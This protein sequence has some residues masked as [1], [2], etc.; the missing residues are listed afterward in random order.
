[1]QLKLAPWNWFKPSSKIFLLTIWRRYFFCGSFVLFM[2]CVCN[3][4]ASVHGCL[5]VT[6]WERADLLAVVCDVCVFIHF[7]RWYPRPGVVLDC[8][9]SW[10]LPPFLLSLL[11][12]AT[13]VLQML[14]IP[15]ITL[16]SFFLFMK[17]FFTA[18]WWMTHG[19]LERI[20][21]FFCKSRLQSIYTSIVSCLY[22][23]KTHT[24]FSVICGVSF[25][26]RAMCLLNVCSVLT[27]SMLISLEKN[28]YIDS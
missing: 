19:G 8:I 13:S 14:R 15:I 26:F 23:L 6:C 28:S 17:S 20:T 7:P 24:F 25:C 9:N 2:S 16:I 1:M 27:T 18:W 21:C 3:A 5:V 4:F 11:Q 22:S 10:S 12:L